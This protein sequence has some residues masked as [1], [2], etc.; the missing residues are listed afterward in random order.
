MLRREAGVPVAVPW[1]RVG[2]S[3]T[4]AMRIVTVG[5]VVGLAAAVAMAVFGLPSVDLHGPLHRMGIMDPLC[6]GTRSARLT[7][8]GRL[9][10]AWEYNPLGIAATVAAAAAVGRVIIVVAARRWVNVQVSW[11]SRR[12]RVAV[13]ILVALLI[14]LEIRQQGRA[15]LLMRRY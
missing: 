2:W 15:D 12:V 5:G 8:Q 14:L 1:V 6:G 3:S 7:A 9:G 4:D 13:A 10:E 11:T